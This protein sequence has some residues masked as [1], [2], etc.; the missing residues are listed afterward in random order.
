[1]REVHNIKQ[2]LT[3]KPDYMGFIFY[4]PSPRYV[5]EDWSLTAIDFKHTAKVG[6]LSMSLCL[7][8]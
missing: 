8:L 6:V 1:M 5:G 3:L 4:A 2:V 7:I